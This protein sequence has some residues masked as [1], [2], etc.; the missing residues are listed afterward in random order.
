V[1]YDD[2][3]SSTIYVPASLLVLG[4]GIGLVLEGGWSWDDAWIIG[5]L[6]I[7][8]TAFLLGFLFYL[9]LGRRLEAAVETHGL[10]SREAQAVARTI[11]AGSR[12]DLLLLFGAVFLMTTK[13][14]L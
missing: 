6:A 8:A 7:F 14:G 3:L 5:G 4:A 12:V 13:P 9:P 10:G 11:T 1:R 2:K